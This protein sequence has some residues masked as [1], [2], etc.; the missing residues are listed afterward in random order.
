M[1]DPKRTMFFPLVGNGTGNV[2]EAFM[3]SVMN[4][5]E[6]FDVQFASV[7]YGPYVGWARNRAATLFLATDIEYLFFV[8]MD[9]AFTRQ[10][11]FRLFDSDEPII[12][13]M[14]FIK[15]TKRLL[16]C[17]V[18][19]AGKGGLL[20][21]G[22]VEN[23]ARTGTGFMR[24]HRS[25]FEKLKETTATYKDADGL[26]DYDFFPVGPS[27]DEYLAEDWGFCDLAREAGFK[28]MLDT[29]IQV[30]HEGTAFYPL[31]EQVT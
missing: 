16:P 4:L 20:R 14:Y 21:T 28:I 13:G 30:L 29:G 19:F 2:K 22:G 10:H 17:F 15:T 11:V 3:L 5:F 12:G 1:L 9:I 8:D 18:H 24:I 31:P 6:H 26:V 23:V 7:S 27:S 25:V